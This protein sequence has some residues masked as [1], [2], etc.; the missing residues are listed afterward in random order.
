MPD[1]DPRIEAVA[2]AVPDHDV[3]QA[4]LVE[5][6]RAFVEERAPELLDMLPVFENAGV[7]TRHLAKPVPWYLDEHGWEDRNAEFARSGVELCTRAVRSVLDDAG[8]PPSTIDG[9]VFVT[10]TGLATPSLDAHLVGELGLRSDVTRTPMWGLGCAGGVAGLARAA[11]MAAARP[12]GRYLLVSLELC[13]LAFLSSDMSK[14]NIVA[15]AIFGDGCA[16]AL[17]AGHRLE[18]DGPRVAGSASHIWPDSLDV[19]GWDVLDEGLA[20]VFSRSIPRRARDDMPAVL[21]A[22]C[23]QQGIS[24]DYRALFHPGGAAVIEAYQEGL[25]HPPDRYDDTRAVLRDHGNMS[26]PTALFVLDR[27]LK[28]APLAHGESGIVS[29]LGPGFAAELVHVQG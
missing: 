6:A 26:S 13:S 27:S 10:T 18:A 8:L 7:Q 20:V 28:G 24:D 4:D 5:V 3:D 1:T 15:A 16:A 9:I 29:A 25:G 17:V 22:F 11:E 21:R 23:K 14:K 19:M 2:T 12:D